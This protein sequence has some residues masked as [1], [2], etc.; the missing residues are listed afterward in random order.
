M[1]IVLLMLVAKGTYQFKRGS[2]RWRIPAAKIAL[3]LTGFVLCITLGILIDF[4][5]MHS[6]SFGRVFILAF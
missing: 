1:G 2:V 6:L 5:C 4:E 3:Y